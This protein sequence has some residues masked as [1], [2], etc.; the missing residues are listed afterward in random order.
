MFLVRNSLS[1][2]QW[3]CKYTVVAVS[4]VEIWLSIAHTFLCFTKFN[5]VLGISICRVWSH[6]IIFPLDIRFNVNLGRLLTRVGRLRSFLITLL[7]FIDCVF[8]SLDLVV[9]EI[10]VLLR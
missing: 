8:D 2:R 1:W 3:F 4:H 5:K 6:N 10:L 7:D 9:N